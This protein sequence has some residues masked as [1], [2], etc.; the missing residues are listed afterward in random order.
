MNQKQTKD[1]INN[2]DECN[3]RL[4][5]LLG[6]SVLEIIHLCSNIYEFQFSPKIIMPLKRNNSLSQ[7]NY[8]THFSDMTTKLNI[9]GTEII[10]NQ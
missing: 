4:P 3:T 5:L 6:R 9:H 7:N 8:K 2:T 1:E 10:I